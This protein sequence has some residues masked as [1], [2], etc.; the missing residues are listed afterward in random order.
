MEDK[1]HH[2]RRCAWVIFPTVGKKKKK[3]VNI[4]SQYGR[5]GHEM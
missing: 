3:F 5:S 2:T 1:K 4:D